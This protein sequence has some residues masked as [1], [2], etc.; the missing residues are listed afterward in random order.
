MKPI[1]LRKS[2]QEKLD[3]MKANSHKEYM[4]HIASTKAWAKFRKIGL[5][6]GAVLCGAAL[7]VFIPGFIDGI[8][9][10]QVMIDVATNPDQLFMANQT[11]TETLLNAISVC[12][13][14]GIVGLTSAIGSV[15]NAK[16]EKTFSNLLTLERANMKESSKVVTNEYAMSS[17]KANENVTTKTNEVKKVKANTVE[18]ENSKEEDRTI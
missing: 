4:E 17:E 15:M 11:M 9:R 8:N 2:E 16:R 3:K 5:M 7:A 14:F 10:A 6:I 1:K 12:G 18:I 13:G